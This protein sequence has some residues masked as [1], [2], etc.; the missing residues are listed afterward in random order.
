MAVT[1]RLRFE[2]LRRDGFR[3]T[4]CGSS[5]SDGAELHVDHVVP[6]ALGGTDDPSN[7]TTSCADCNAGKS[8]S[9]PTPEQVAAVEAADLTWR[10]QVAEALEAIKLEHE[11]RAVLVDSF[12]G[13]W[14]SWHWTDQS[15]NQHRLGKAANWRSTVG[16]ML[17]RGMDL[18]H[19]NMCVEIAMNANPDD[20]WA[21]FCGVVWRTLKQAQGGY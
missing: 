18:E 16:L 8:S 2:I 15:G 19:L 11:E 21:Y 3:C 6:Q 13:I 9:S 1:K 17:D 7:L 20:E 14:D 4:Y 5:P 12:A 10:H